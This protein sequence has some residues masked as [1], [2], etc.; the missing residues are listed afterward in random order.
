MSRPTCAII[1]TT[2]LRANLQRVSACAPTQRIMAVIKANAYGHGAIPIAKVLEPQVDAFAVACIEEAL[3]LR[4]AGITVPIV[5]LEGFFHADELPLV[6]A[7]QLQ[8]VVHNATQLEHLLRSRLAKPIQV[9]LKVDTGMHRL[10]FA[11][12]EIEAIYGRLQQCSQVSPPIRLLSHLACADDRQDQTTS[13]QTQRFMTLVNALKVEAS[14]A[15]S[16]GILAWPQTHV[17]W[18]RPG[19]MLYGVSPFTDTT[20]TV[21]GLQPVMQLQSVLTSVKY[22]QIGECVGYGRTWRCPENMPIGVVAIGYADGYPRHVPSGTPVLVN[23]KRVPLIGRVSMDMITVDLRT[24]PHAQVG[25]PVILWGNDLPIEE[26]AHLAGTIAYELLCNVSK[27]IYQLS[28]IN[29]Q[30]NRAEIVFR[31]FG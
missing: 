13:V 21:E 19:I 6:A 16:A 17:D 14:F 30:P 25:D 31:H 20:A 3:P 26:I 9:W 27:R 4:E 23:G 29:H 22:C 11:P 7:H 8:I 12:Y 18:V 5:L 24:Q 10:G 1:D 28:V 15:N 2:A